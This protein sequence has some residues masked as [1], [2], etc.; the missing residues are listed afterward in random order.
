MIRLFFL[1]LFIFSLTLFSAEQPERVGLVKDIKGPD[2]VLVVNLTTKEERQV[3]IQDPV[4]VKDKFITRKDQAVLLSLDDETQI[5]I[6]PFSSFVVEELLSEKSS[7]TL[8]NLFYGFVHNKVKKQYGSDRPYVVKTPV[9]VMGVRGTN[10]TVEHDSRLRETKV[11][12]LEGVVAMASLK[13][14][15][16]LDRTLSG[17]LD[18]ALRALNTT[19]LAVQVKAGQQSRLTPAL[20]TPEPPRPFEKKEFQQNIERRFPTVAPSVLETTSKSGPAI[21]APAAGTPAGNAHAVRSGAFETKQRRDNFDQ[22]A[23]RLHGST[24]STVGGKEVRFRGERVEAKH[25]SR[26]RDSAVKRMGVLEHRKSHNA[27]VRGVT[28]K[29]TSSA[30]TATSGATATTGSTATT[31]TSI[32][33]RSLGSTLDR[34]I[35][36][37]AGTAT[38]TTSG[39]PSGSTG[40]TTLIDG[41][42][43]SVNVVPKP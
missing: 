41:T 23:Q 8:L 34:Q 25:M 6:G 28:D 5:T 20:Q 29:V 31:S 7:R 3:K 2:S 35:S 36:N 32:I 12:T 21:G 4:L 27:S 24:P 11:H 40:S 43:D 33:D 15:T 39:S 30:S 1:F 13:S 38:S 14:A 26:F 9:A 42:K 22:Q 16:T 10:F 37:T 19:S 17:T 18:G